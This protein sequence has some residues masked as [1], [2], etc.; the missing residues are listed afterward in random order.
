MHLYLDD[1]ISWIT[2]LLFATLTVLFF[3][4]SS[5]TRYDS[6]FPPVHL[7]NDKVVEQPGE[8]AGEVEENKNNQLTL[9]QPY[10]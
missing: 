10:Q 1:F 5:Y 4:K 8:Y 9:G 3:V 7:L 6:S 2:G